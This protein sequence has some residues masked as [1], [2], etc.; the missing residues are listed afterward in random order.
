MIKV[1]LK[2]GLIGAVLSVILFT[3]LYF[4]KQNPLVEGRIF[5]FF[6]IPVMIF[7]SIK[8]YRDY[9]NG[10][11]LWFWQGM[12][13]GF[14]NYLT[15]GIVTATFIALFL[16]LEPQVLT[17]FIGDRLV[18]LETHK[19]ELLE[20]MDL[21]S[22][23]RTLKDVQEISVFDVVGDEVLRKSIIGLFLT[24]IISVFLRK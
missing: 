9:N 15:I 17:D 7:F 14:L 21:A 10:Q 1:A 18:Y 12:S 16:Q 6:V 24:I 2:Y 5:D 3:T 23:E 22:Y 20:E 8:E 19:K 4:I 13:V 11:R